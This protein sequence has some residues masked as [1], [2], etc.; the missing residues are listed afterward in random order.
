[1]K[2]AVG[3]ALALGRLLEITNVLLLLLLLLL[4]ALLCEVDWGYEFRAG[5]SWVAAA[6][7]HRAL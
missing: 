6:A 5:N 2:N 3:A 4:H 7:R 1:M